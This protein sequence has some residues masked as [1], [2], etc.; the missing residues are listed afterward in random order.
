[1][2]RFVCILSCLSL[3]SVILLSCLASCAEKG[4][5]PFPPSKQTETQAISETDETSHGK[6]NLPPLINQKPVETTAPTPTEPSPDQPRLIFADVLPSEGISGSVQ[7]ENSVTVQSS[8]FLHLCEDD[9]FVDYDSVDLDIPN[10]TM[11]ICGYTPELHYDETKL[12]LDSD[13]EITD[14]FHRYTMEQEKIYVLVEEDTDRIVSIDSFT[15]TVSRLPKATANPITEEQAQTIAT[16]FLLT[17]AQIPAEEL[18][19]YNHVSVRFQKIAVDEPVYYV[20]FSIHV[21]GYST[22][23]A[24]YVRITDYGT[25]FSY[26]RNNPGRFAPFVDTVTA[27]DIRDALIALGDTVDFPNNLFDTREYLVVDEEGN[28]YVCY[29]GFYTIEQSTAEG[30]ETDPLAGMVMECMYYSQV[31]PSGG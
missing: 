2:K 13:G 21:G 22:G 12:I 29:T 17:C 11:N 14:V 7:N 30:A 24:I 8:S 25:V 9:L 16:N 10:R 19:Q 3:I 1:M 6:S 18:S 20:C 5:Q 15:N 27:K 31:I 4:A 23:E 28:L 26:Y